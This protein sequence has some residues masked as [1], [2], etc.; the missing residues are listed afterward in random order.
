MKR[1][2]ILL[3]CL[4]SVGFISACAHPPGGRRHVETNLA[5]GVGLG[6][7]VGIVSAVL[8]RTY[9]PGHRVKALPK[10]VRTVSH[11]GTSYRYA[12]GVYYRHHGRGFEVVNPPIGLVIQVLP[13]KARR[14][15][16]RGDPF[17]YCEG[18]YYRRSGSHF[19]VA[20]VPIDSR[21]RY[22]SG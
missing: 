12:D 7:G 5:L 3:V 21:S 15:S 17:Y 13:S 22:E 11:R 14:V 16:V 2:R 6:L 20:E 1:C 4:C 8:H 10:G 19:V 18:V 9:S